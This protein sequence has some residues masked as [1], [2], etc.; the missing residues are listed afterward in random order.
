[1]QKQSDNNKN[2]QKAFYLTQTQAEKLRKQAY[3]TRESESQIVRN[4]IDKS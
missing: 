1:M 2:V 4:L 3:E